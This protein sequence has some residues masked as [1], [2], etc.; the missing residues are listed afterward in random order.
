MGGC[1]VVKK[2]LMKNTTGGKQSKLGGNRQTDGKHSNCS[3]SFLI[4][5][6]KATVIF[7]SCFCAVQLRSTRIERENLDLN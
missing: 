6:F 7:I 1:T 3:L 2:L 5:A 4:F